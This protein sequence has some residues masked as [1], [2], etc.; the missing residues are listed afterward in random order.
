[1]EVVD[2]YRPQTNGKAERSNRFS[3]EVGLSAAVPLNAARDRALQA[4][5]HRYNMQHANSAL[6]GLSPASRINNLPGYWD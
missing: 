1:M 5:V 3:G 2:E 4:G 6:G